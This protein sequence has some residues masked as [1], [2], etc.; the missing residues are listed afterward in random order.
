MQ[1]QISLKL[2]EITRILFQQAVVKHQGVTIHTMTDNFNERVLLQ[3]GVQTNKHTHTH[4]HT[5]ICTNIH[6]QH[7]T[8]K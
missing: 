5:Q 8:Q 7:N 4:T 1:Q 3:F 6:T 2:L